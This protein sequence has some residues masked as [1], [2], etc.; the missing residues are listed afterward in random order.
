MS[1][2]KEG[3]LRLEDTLTGIRQVYKDKKVV[4]AKFFYALKRNMDLIKD[5]VTKIRLELMNSYQ[6]QRNDEK[7]SEYEKKRIELCKNHAKKD[8]NGGPII[9]ERGH[10]DIA[11]ENMETF[12][13]EYAELNEEY[14]EVMEKRKNDAEAINKMLSEPIDIK[15]Y[16]IKI[17]MLP[18]NEEVLTP[19]DIDYLMPIIEDEEV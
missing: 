9:T 12:Q 2:T 15:L 16:K 17:D 1:M 8:E 14:K 19:E 18:N 10:F 5:E 13:K 4:N 3:L 7:D 6:T 11:P